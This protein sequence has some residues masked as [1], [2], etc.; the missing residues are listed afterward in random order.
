MKIHHRTSWG[1]Y[2]ATIFV[3][4]SLINNANA[5]NATS[6]CRK[7]GKGGCLQ[8]GVFHFGP[9]YLIFDGQDGVNALGPT[10]SV[11][12]KIGDTVILRRKKRFSIKT[13]DLIKK[14]VL[15]TSCFIH[16]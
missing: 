4:R 3:K 11:P 7:W 15:F 1:C 14:K 13:S 9:G 8:E 12:K 2:K 5:M 6:S 16:N 10:A